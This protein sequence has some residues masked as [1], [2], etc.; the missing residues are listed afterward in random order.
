METTTTIEVFQTGFIGIA[1]DEAVAKFHA[2]YAGRKV[3]DVK[4]VYAHPGGPTGRW[5]GIDF[6]HT[7][8]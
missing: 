1:K 5:I 8:A 6:T 2:H 7:A 4:Y 3:L